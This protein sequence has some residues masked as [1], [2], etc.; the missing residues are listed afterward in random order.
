[1]DVIEV[2]ETVKRLLDD[3][4]THGPLGI[5]D[6]LRKEGIKGI[7]RRPASCP[8]ANYIRAHLPEYPGVVSV[9][10][11]MGIRVYSDEI[12]EHSK[13]MSVGVD[14]PEVVCGFIREFDIGAF[15]DLV[16][17]WTRP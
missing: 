4:S 2:E 10:S 6:V 7:R 8:I 14:V 9:S 16:G 13:L 5:A 17:E 11:L 3:L 12:G 1:M 15:D